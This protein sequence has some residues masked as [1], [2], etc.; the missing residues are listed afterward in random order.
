MT[1]AGGRGRPEVSTVVLPN[2]TEEERP[3]MAER[4]PT[5]EDTILVATFVN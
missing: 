5:P 1:Q 4:K 3:A 2:H